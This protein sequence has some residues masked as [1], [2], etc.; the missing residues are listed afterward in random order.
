[1]K[2]EIPELAIIIAEQKEIKA[3][4]KE[5]ISIGN[6]KLCY[7]IDEAAALM[8]LASGSVRN[9]I[10]S[11]DLEAVQ[12]KKGGRWSIPASSLHT[13]INQNKINSHRYLN[14]TA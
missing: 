1:M 10:C 2:V 11:G 12:P 4:L 13:Y 3:L 6:N 8:G 9:Y 5:L 7:T 14:I